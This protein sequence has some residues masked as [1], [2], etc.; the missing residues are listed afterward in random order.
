MLFTLLP[1]ATVQSSQPPLRQPVKILTIMGKILSMGGPLKF[2]EMGICFI[3]EE[4]SSSDNLDSYNGIDFKIDSNY[5]KMLNKNRIQADAM[6]HIKIKNGKLYHNNNLIDFDL[7]KIKWINKAVFWQ[8]WVVAIGQTSKEKVELNNPEP[9]E[10]IY[11][12]WKTRKGGSIYLVNKILP[13][14]RIIT[15]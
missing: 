13:D 3:G 7:I 2:D 15:K 11:Y 4:N 9:R 12:N 8:D 1:A 14:F 10:L 5:W 6:S